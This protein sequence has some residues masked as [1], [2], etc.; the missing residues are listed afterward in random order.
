MD[1]G[2]LLNFSPY[3]N[4]DF[5]S[6]DKGRVSFSVFAMWFFCVEHAYAWLS[7]RNWGVC[8][9]LAYI[10]R[11]TPQSATVS[12]IVAS[13]TLI[14][15]RVDCRA[16]ATQETGCIPSLSI[17]IMSP[18]NTMW[19]AILDADSSDNLLYSNFSNAFCV[20]ILL[21]SQRNS[22]FQKLEVH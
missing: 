8:Q 20:G 22:L 17:G 15:M 16:A 10:W 2:I 13:P 3:R 21:H 18:R 6:K 11:Y 14:L 12:L 1:A 7:S 9:I 5:F 4:C 19:G